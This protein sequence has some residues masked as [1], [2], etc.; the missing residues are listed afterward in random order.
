LRSVDSVRTVSS[1]AR[2]ELP[3]QAERRVLQLA[4]L[5]TAVPAAIVSATGHPDL[6]AK[7]P[8]QVMWLLDLDGPARPS[9]IVDVVGLTSGGTTKLLDRLES[10]GMIERLRRHQPATPEARC[11]WPCCLLRAARPP[12]RDWPSGRGG[13]GLGGRERSVV[14]VRG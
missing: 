14:R 4:S 12:G 7:A 8:M 3:S 13:V 2:E 10:A 1:G 9:A 5:G 6:V 11:C